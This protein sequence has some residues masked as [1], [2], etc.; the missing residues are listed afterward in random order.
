MDTHVKRPADPERQPVLLRPLEVVVSD[1]LLIMELAHLACVDVNDA[2]VLDIGTRRTYPRNAT[3]ARARGY[4][5]QSYV[6]SICTNAR[7]PS[8]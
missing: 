7:T 1:V 2:S 3:S 8:Q 4:A 6:S 5:R